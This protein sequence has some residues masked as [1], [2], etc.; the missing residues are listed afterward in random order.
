M[1]IAIPIAM[2]VLAAVQMGK[3]WYD[4][5]QAKKEAEEIQDKLDDT[6]TPTDYRSV[7]A[8]A[9]RA[10]GSGMSQEMYA[11]NLSR[12]EQGRINTMERINRTENTP[13]VKMAAGIAANR[14][15]TDSITDVIVK[16]AQMQKESD[17]Y[18]DS[19]QLMAAGADVKTEE[20]N[21]RRNMIKY[22]MVDAQMQAGSEAI[23]AGLSNATGALYTYG[24]NQQLIDSS[25]SPATNKVTDYYGNKVTPNVPYSS[26]PDYSR[27]EIATNIPSAAMPAEQATNIPITG[28]PT[29]SQQTNDNYPTAKSVATTPTEI[30]TKANETQTQATKRPWVTQYSKVSDKYNKKWIAPQNTRIDSISPEETSEYFAINSEPFNEVPNVVTNANG[31]KKNVSVAIRFMDRG[32]T[33]DGYIEWFEKEHGVRLSDGDKRKINKWYS[34]YV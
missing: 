4:T 21:L 18:A 6:T 5:A 32:F 11:S 26:S 14:A 2:A 19:V 33:S 24:L 10:A 25:K 12:A 13:S 3:G 28:S 27:Q 29:V 15:S 31:D 9:R 20:S 17:R 8:R 34:K 7:A 30:A 23:N 22:Q 16:N 1:A